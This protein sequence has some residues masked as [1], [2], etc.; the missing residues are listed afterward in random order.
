M[1][2][3]A[4]LC[5]RCSSAAAIADEHKSWSCL[6]GFNYLI[7]EYYIWQIFA[8][9]YCT[10]SPWLIKSL[11]ANFINQKC[12]KR[13]NCTFATEV[14][15]I[16]HLQ[17][18]VT[19]V[20]AR[21]RI[22]TFPLPPLY[23]CIHFPCTRR[24]RGT[25]WLYFA[26]CYSTPRRSDAGTENI[27]CGWGLFETY[28]RLMDQLCFIRPRWCILMAYYKLYDCGNGKWICFTHFVKAQIKRGR[29]SVC[30]S[31]WL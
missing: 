4:P 16:A 17:A 6:S 26:V 22:S 21:W 30:L 1:A 2:Q 13:K 27:Q 18:A 24:C 20:I 7:K 3:L 19:T 9:R 12:H 29:L 14:S 10:F 28:T 15:L 11:L 23:C 31:T 5:L 8:I 25:A